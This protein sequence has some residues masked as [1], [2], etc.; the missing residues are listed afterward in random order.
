MRDQRRGQGRHDQAERERGRRA[1]ARVVPFREEPPDP[2]PRPAG[3][4]GLLAGASIR[5]AAKIMTACEV[6]KVCL[7]Y[8]LER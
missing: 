3:L 1:K 6:P 4:P 7:A 5:D 8:E 2:G